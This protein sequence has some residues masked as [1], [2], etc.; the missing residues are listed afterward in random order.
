MEDSSATKAAMQISLRI[1]ILPLWSFPTASSTANTRVYVG[2]HQKNGFRLFKPG[3][4]TSFTLL[5]FTKP[6]YLS[7]ALAPKT[8]P[9]FLQPYL[10]LYSLIILKERE[11]EDIRI[12]TPCLPPLSILQDDKFI[13]APKSVGRLECRPNIRCSRSP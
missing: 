6:K 8:L 11:V 13:R 4:G 9:K 10:Y 12:L 1:W 5:S 2:T 3:R 7:K